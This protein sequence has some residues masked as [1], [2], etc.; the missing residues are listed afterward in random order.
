M[1]EPSPLLSV[2][3]TV[4]N[5]A[6]D[7]GACLRSIAL[8]E[9]VDDYGIEIIVVDDRS[10]DDIATIV[11]TVGLYNIHLI[12]IDE[13]TP[14]NLTSRQVA[15][16]RGFERAKGS[17]I[18]LIDS[19]G[20]APARW[21]REVLDL[22]E[23]TGADA[24]A[25]PLAFR[26]PPAVISALQTVDSAF[27]FSWCR[28]MNRF[29]IKTGGYFGNFAVRRDAYWSLGGVR[30]LGFALTEDLSFVRALHGHGKKISF[31]NGHPV[32]VKASPSWA[33]LLARSVRISTG[34]FSCLAVAFFLWV[35]SLPLLAIGGIL[36]GGSFWWAVLVRLF[37]GEG[38][39]ASSLPGK[40]RPLHIPFL[41]CYE[42][43]IMLI[44]V[45]VAIRM[46][47]SR[48]IRWGGVTYR[49]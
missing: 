2:I 23:S 26:P 38:L 33:T 4:H 45:C 34:G 14:C 36:W 24:V 5:G 40:I 19:D 13:Y 49:R 17:V 18:F 20:I 27:Y 42:P 48:Q 8:Q 12:R 32:S 25:G 31:L 39:I 43:T 35:L 6:R 29:E 16:D 15:L 11:Q 10:V 9:G 21:L 30:A 41:L 7:I 44:A 3:I 37:L 46:A 28:I 47:I 22:L 1:N